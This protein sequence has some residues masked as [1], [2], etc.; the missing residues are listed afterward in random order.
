MMIS[1]MQRWPLTIPEISHGK[2]ICKTKDRHELPP[3]DEV[4]FKNRKIA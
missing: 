3:L 4:I 1:K 2:N